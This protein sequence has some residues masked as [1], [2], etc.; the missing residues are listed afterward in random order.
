MTPESVQ[1]F[2][3]LCRARNISTQ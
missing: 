1:S 2:S 3:R